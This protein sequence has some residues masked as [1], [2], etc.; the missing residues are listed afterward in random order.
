MFYSSVNPDRANKILE[1]LHNQLNETGLSVNTIEII[2]GTD[3]GIYAWI[4]A[5]F[6]RETLE[7]PQVKQ[8]LPNLGSTVLSSQKRVIYLR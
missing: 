2:S 3:E 8:Y 1:Q 5:N 7:I 4:T 6:L